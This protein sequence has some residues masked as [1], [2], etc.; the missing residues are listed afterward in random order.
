MYSVENQEKFA[1][2]LRE[3]NWLMC[4]LLKILSLPILYSVNVILTCITIV[5]HSGVLNQVIKPENRG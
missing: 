3:K 5:S 1:R 4:Y 2:L